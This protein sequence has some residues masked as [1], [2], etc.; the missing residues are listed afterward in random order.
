MIPIIIRETGHV[1]TLV[2]IVAWI[3]SKLRKS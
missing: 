1:P 3:I 2:Q